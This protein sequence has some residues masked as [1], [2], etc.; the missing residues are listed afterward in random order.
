MKKVILL[1]FVLWSCLLSSFG[2]V[3]FKIDGFSDKYYGRAYFSDTSEVYCEGWVAVYDRRTNKELFRVNADE[4][5]YK[6]HGS[7][8]KQNIA[9]YPYGEH[10]VLIYQ[11]F[12]FD[13]MKDFALMDGLHSYDHGPS[14]HIFFTSKKGFIFSPEL[15]ALTHENCGMF[16]VD[17]EDKTLVTMTKDGDDWRKYSTY[18]IEDFMPFLISTFKEDIRNEPI[19]A[20]TTEEWNGEKMIEKS[21]TIFDTN[22]QNIKSLFTFHVDKQNKNIILY[23]CD[24]RQLYY[25]ITNSNAEFELLYPEINKEGKKD[26]YYSRKKNALSFWNK[27]TEYRITDVNGIAR[28]GIL[29]KGKTYEWKGN[30]KNRKCSLK[31]LLN[32][33]LDNL[34]YGN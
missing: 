11:D 16:S 30:S 3:I 8:L 27:D 13:G 14:Y 18:I 4:L 2:Q 5:S 34:S 10:S 23:S 32:H 21:F 6:L 15:T 33:T 20:I 17:N 28:I 24:G 29:T 22:S 19:K 25:T 1:V 31:A 12:N 7:Q 26:F 9:K